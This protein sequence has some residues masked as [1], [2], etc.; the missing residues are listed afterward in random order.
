MCWRAGG[1]PDG[2]RGVTVGRSSDSCGCVGCSENGELGEIMLCVE[3]I[4]AS[5]M[6]LLNV[7]F[8]YVGVWCLGLVQ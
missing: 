5:Q 2:L 7:G 3:I 4:I 8:L 1:I 6:L